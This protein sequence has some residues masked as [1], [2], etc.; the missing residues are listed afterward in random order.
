MGS[1]PNGGQALR[2]SRGE[3]EQGSLAEVE[4]L[5]QA[6][7]ALIDEEE[8][9]LKSHMLAVQENAD[10]LTEEGRLL[11]TVQGED[12][13]DYDIDAYAKRLDAIL[14]RKLEMF[15]SLKG[16]LKAFRLH[17]REEEVASK[18]VHSMPTY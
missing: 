10:L 12:V 14:D 15:T 4:Q 8:R 6:V 17:L 13:V 3:S 5:H 9:L 2:R 18:R 7:N 11:S 16:R 1:G